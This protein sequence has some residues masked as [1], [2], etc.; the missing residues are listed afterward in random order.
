MNVEESK[1]EE[2]MLPVADIPRLE[3]T[4]GVET[5]KCEEGESPKQRLLSSTTSALREFDN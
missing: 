3:E 2:V 1:S 5:M 4:E